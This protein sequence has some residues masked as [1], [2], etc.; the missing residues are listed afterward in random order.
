VSEGFQCNQKVDIFSLRLNDKAVGH[1]GLDRY[2]GGTGFFLL[3]KRVKH[4][5]GYAIQPIYVG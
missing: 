5:A 3:A 4:A 1:G 2:Y